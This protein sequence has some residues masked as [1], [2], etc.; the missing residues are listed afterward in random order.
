MRIAARYQQK[1]EV[2]IDPNEVLKLLKDRW[3]NSLDVTIKVNGLKPSSSEMYINERSQWEHWTS[4]PHGSG[5]T[6]TYRKVTPEEIEIEKAF[7]LIMNFTKIKL[8]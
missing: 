4:Y 2:D 5:T 7:S 6:T 8:T 1:V 3:R